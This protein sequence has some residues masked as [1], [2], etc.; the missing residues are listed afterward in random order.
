MIP[1][2]S[3]HTNESLE[4]YLRDRLN[5]PLDFDKLSV[6]HAADVAVVGAASS[7]KFVATGHLLTLLSAL[8]TPTD[9]QNDFWNA[10]WTASGD[11][12]L[13]PGNF[14]HLVLRALDG[15]AAGL[16]LLLWITSGKPWT[17]GS[18]SVAV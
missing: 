13:L 11:A 9:D 8:P 17:V 10:L 6:K 15:D 14:K 5:L 4:V 7:E 16:G 2:F 18:G 1:R 12:Y 3:G